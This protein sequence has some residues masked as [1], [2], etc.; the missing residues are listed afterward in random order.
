MNKEEKAAYRAVKLI[1]N[2]NGVTVEPHCY[3][4]EMVIMGFN[5]HVF[6]NPKEI[7][8]YLEQIMDFPMKLETTNT[9]PV[10]PKE[11]REIAAR[12]NCDVTTYERICSAAN[13]LE[14]LEKI[15]AGEK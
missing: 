5:N 8:E 2:I 14:K 15:K 11:L 7:W 13:Q 10:K 6:N 9:D 12:L 4:N 3:P 1:R